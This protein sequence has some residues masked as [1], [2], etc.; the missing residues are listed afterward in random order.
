MT[1]E[2]GRLLFLFVTGP[3]SRRVDHPGFREEPADIYV[4]RHSIGIMALFAVPRYRWFLEMR[5]VPKP[6]ARE[7]ESRSRSV[8]SGKLLVGVTHTAITCSFV[9]VVRVAG[10]A[11]LVTGKGHLKAAGQGLVT[12]FAR[13]FRQVR[14]RLVR[15]HVVSMRE[16]LDPEL[17]H[18][19]RK[20]HQS[21]FDWLDGPKVAPF[22]EILPLPESEVG[23]DVS[24]AIHAGGMIR[25][26]R[27]GPI[28]HSHVAHPALERLVSTAI[29]VKPRQVTAG[30]VGYLKLG[31]P[32]F[33]F[34][35][36]L[37]RHR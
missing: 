37:F 6:E 31:S 1:L 15:V 32:F 17:L 30:D 27:P 20:A 5:R 12:A 4:F 19:C 29:V 25:Q 34:G 11:R 28:I 33:R 21:V 22:A 24:V 7:S 14:V 9:A 3:A 35:C 23:V 16:L 13:E 18:G 10:I 26:R 8:G 36:G 2:A